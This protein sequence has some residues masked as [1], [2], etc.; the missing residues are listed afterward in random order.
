[1]LITGAKCSTM[2]VTAHSNTQDFIN[3]TARNTEIIPHVTSMKLL[4]VVIQYNLKWDQQIDSMVAKANTHK[5]FITILKRSGV[6]FDDLVRIVVL[7]CG[8][9]W[10]M[11]PQFGTQDSPSS[12][13][14]SWS[15]YRGR[16][17]ECYCLT[18]VTAKSG[19]YQDYQPCLSDAQ[20]WV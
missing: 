18:P 14:M 3:I 16:S 2:H 4:G 8:L 13:L 11:L 15:R 19:I 10:S 1:M 17:S 12:S 7:L 20:S 5:Y 6:Q 9:C